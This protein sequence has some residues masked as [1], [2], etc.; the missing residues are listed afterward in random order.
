MRRGN[1]IILVILAVSTIAVYPETVLH[2]VLHDTTYDQTGNPYIVDSTI[3]VPKGGK[4]SFTEGC[5]VLA[6]PYTGIDVHGNFFVRGTVEKPVIFTTIND[7]R[8][9]PKAEQFPQPLDWNGIAFQPA[10]DTVLME[11][12][13][14][15]YSVYGIKSWNS[16]IVIYKG[17]FDKNGQYNLVI[18]DAMQPITSN[19]PFSYNSESAL[20]DSLEARERKVQYEQRAKIKKIAS[21]TALTSGVAIGGIDAVFW[22]RYLYYRNK[23]ADYRGSQDDLEKLKNRRSAY[24]T[25]SITAAVASGVLLSASFSLFI[26]PVKS[27]NKSIKQKTS[28]FELRYHRGELAAVVFF[29]SPVNYHPFCR[30]RDL[31]K[32]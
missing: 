30:G 17:L 19:I 10:S 3:V 29:K 4:V 1:V 2:G 11:N 26:I 7:N 21:I 25:A 9:N 18:N 6:K 14:L 32:E 16:H 22:S 27:L 12:F 8:Y 23:Y 5:V 31:P 28:S 20:R 13:K 15:T 24:K